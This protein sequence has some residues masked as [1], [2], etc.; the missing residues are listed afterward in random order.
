MID[1]Y[2]DYLRYIDLKKRIKVSSFWNILNVFDLV[3]YLEKFVSSTKI[4]HFWILWKEPSICLNFDFIGYYLLTSIEMKFG[5]GKSLNSE[6]FDHVLDPTNGGYTL[7]YKLV[8]SEAYH[9]PMYS[10]GPSHKDTMWP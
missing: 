4:K 6:Q 1:Y 5:S 2:C 10:F 8:S 9:R 3:S 7:A